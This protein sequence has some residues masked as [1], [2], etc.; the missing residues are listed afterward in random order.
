VGALGEPMAVSR[1][2]DLPADIHLGASTGSL[3]ALILP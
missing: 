3:T 1:T 2:M